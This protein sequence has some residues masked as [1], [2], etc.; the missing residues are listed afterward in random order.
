MSNLISNSIKYK[1]DNVKLKIHI[2][3]QTT[4]DGFILLKFKDNGLGIDLERDKDKVFSLFKRA[5]NIGEGNGMALYMLKK[6]LIRNKGSISVTSEVNKGAEF[7]I[8]FKPKN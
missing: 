6:V 5:H 2:S 3:T 1:R 4:K 7:S 8:H